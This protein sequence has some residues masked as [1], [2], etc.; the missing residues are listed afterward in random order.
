MLQSFYAIK[1]KGI[2]MFKIIMKIVVFL[3]LSLGLYA[4]NGLSQGHLRSVSPS[5]SESGVSQDVAVDVKF[6]LPLKEK[7]VKKHTI[8]L[9]HNNKKIRGLTMLVGDDTLRFT[10]NKPLEEGR[11]IVKVKKVKLQKET[12]HDNVQHE[13][14]NGF[15]RFI[16]WLCSLFY[17]NPADCSLCKKICGNSSDTIKTKK[18]KYTF[19][20]EDNS[21]KVVNIVLSETNIELN[22]GNETILSATVNYDD[23]STKDITENAVWQIADG[24]IVSIDNNGSILGLKEGNTTLKAKYEGKVSNT[25]TVVVYKEINGY[26]LPPEPD[27]TLNNATLLGIDSN[28]NGIRDDVERYIITR[29]AQDPK[30]PKTKIAIALQYAWASQKIIENPTM[31]SSQFEDDA[32]ACESYWLD[33]KTKDLSGFEYGKFSK[34]HSVFG[35]Y[36]IKD[37]IYNT[38]KRIERKFNYNTALSGNILVDKKDDTLDRCKTDID[39]LGE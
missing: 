37:K 33:Q 7:S 14:K 26:R 15:Q 9:K 27:P 5:A 1:I 22:E 35:S 38:R 18:I 30:Y 24:S 36:K 20:V 8:V 23:N 19:T 17:G 28:D 32:L 39:K 34:K 4:G 6:D 29:Y 21:P 11:Y 16:Y 12:N 3:G 25:V 13:P 2:V 31:E 10:P